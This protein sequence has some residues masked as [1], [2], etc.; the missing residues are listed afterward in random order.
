MD[1]WLLSA[2]TFLPLLGAVVVAL[3]PRD[4]EHTAKWAALIF[5]LLVA[6]LAVIAFFQYQECTPN[7]QGYCFVEEANW[8]D[9]IGV[10]WRAGID[11]L[12]APLVLLT[13][14]LT[15]L[16]IL[17]SFEVHDR[18][19]IHMALFLLLEMGM[20]GVF[21]ALDLVI[22]FV[23]WEFGLIPMYF[24]IN[25]WGS[26]EERRRHAA[27]KFLLYTMAGSLGL[28]LALQVIGLTIGT[29]DIP[30][31]QAQWPGYTG[32][33]GAL[34]GVPIETVKSIAFVAFFVAFAIKIPVWP[35][36]TWLPDAHTEA[37]TAGSMLLAGVLLKLGAYGMLRL[38]APLFP[39]RRQT[40]P[41]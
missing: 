18:V 31:L 11:G 24:L 19:H 15:P 41:S 12:S 26:D 35:F 34:F 30:A 16:A 13:G 5:A 2:I 17:I 4:L 38:V 22:F 9:L 14:L 8:F 32:D 6:V 28:L 40:P 29:F 7:E 36:H 25:Q 20:M 23:F 21:I 27:I 33:G 3:L 10:R 1:F 37:P 39:S